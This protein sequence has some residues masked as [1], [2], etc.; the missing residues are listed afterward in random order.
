M[1]LRKSFRILRSSA[2]IGLIPMVLSLSAIS[3]ATVAIVSQMG[4]SG[5]KRS[6]SALSEWD[7]NLLNQKALSLGGYFVA[8]N[9]VLCREDGWKVHGGSTSPIRCIWGG[10][11]HD[12]KIKTSSFKVLDYRHLPDGMLELDIE[13]TDSLGKKVL[14]KLEMQ[15]IDWSKSPSF[16]S[17]VGVIPPWNGLADDDN[18][19]VKMKATTLLAVDGSTTKQIEKS[20]AIRRPLGTP[21][22]Q[23]LSSSGGSSVCT[24]EC[25]AGDTLSPHPECRGPLH[26]PGSGATASVTAR[27]TNFGPGAI[28]KLQYERT[29]FFDQ[30]VYPGRPNNLELVDAMDGREVLMPGQVVSRDLPRLCFN[31]IRNYMTNR[32]ETVATGTVARTTTTTDV[33]VATAYRNLSTESFDISVSKFDPEEMK[34]PKFASRYNPFDAATFKPNAKKS[35]I[36][37][38]RIGVELPTF[39]VQSPQEII[40]ETTTTVV[41][42]T[43]PVPRTT[44]GRGGGDGDN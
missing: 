2:G 44:G 11:Y 41:V 29:T 22:M 7:T 42:R 16:R 27:M 32:I 3:V 20:G 8:H 37:P 36:E 43:R 40:T 23:I 39:E 12:P 26:V 35:I 4:L 21:N 25:D 15:L 24:F 9:I 13:N 17:L 28:Y 5:L 19:I 10:D 1:L 38:K 14:T 30:T 33:S 6:S 18:F 31:P 34:D